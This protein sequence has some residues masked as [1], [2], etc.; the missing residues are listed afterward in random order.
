MGNSRNLNPAKWEAKAFK[1]LEALLPVGSS[2]CVAVSGGLDSMVLLHW[3]HG[4]ARK[5]PLKLSVIHVNHQ[6]QPEA[7][8]WQEFVRQQCRSLNIPLTLSRVEVPLDQGLGLEAAAREARYQAFAALR[9]DYLALAHHQDDQVET[10]WLQL[11]RGAGVQGLSAMP[12]LRA[13][14]TLQLIR[15]LLGV[16]RQELEQY[17]KAHQIPFVQ[18]PSNQDPK[19]LR[20]FLRLRL[21]PLLSERFPAWR[22]T[23]ARSAELLG[24]ASQLLSE[25]ARSDLAECADGEGVRVAAAM[26]LGDARAANL[27][28][29]WLTL[30]GVRP[31][32]S[33]R[34]R[35]WLRQSQAAKH[36]QPQLEWDGW[37]LSRH[38]GHWQLHRM[39]L[40]W[41]VLGLENFPSLGEYQL[42]DGSRFSVTENQGK[43]PGLCP[44][45]APGLWQ[46][47]CRV[48]GERIRPRLGGPSRTLKNLFLEAGVPLWQRE[49][50][51][52]LYCDER[53]V[54]VPGLAI[55]A[56]FQ[57]KS[58]GLALR[59]LPAA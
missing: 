6:L 11:L 45:L 43:T 32:A 42:P 21:A 48:G 58:G 33:A 24:E 27:L 28:R 56:E 7:D 9:A 8:A 44:D 57:A 47:R 29:H 40:S 1:D 31:P 51:P 23:M 3:L 16:S 10:L 25:L 36:R 35:E 38:R 5:H 30:Q 26:A 2:L 13:H 12:L 19:I 14:H 17:A 4:F 22:Q 46:L 50:L 55:A 54:A 34:L 41:S 52:L 39:P 15:P 37:V 20:N 59:W 18:D 49:Q 53:L